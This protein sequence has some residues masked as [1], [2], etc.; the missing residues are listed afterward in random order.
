[1]TG[2]EYTELAMKTRMPSSKNHMYMLL[3]LVAEVGELSGKIAK[4][5]RHGV[6]V[7]NGNNFVVKCKNKAEEDA[8]KE[9]IVYELGDCFWQLH[10]LCDAFGLK[11]EDVQKLNLK[12][13]A[14]RK[15]RDVIDG[16]GDY[17]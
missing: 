4:A 1:M 9:A 17:R 14:D 5:I 6:V 15:K 8:L 12:K 2:N 3:N 7:A 10:G 16:S 11:A 13:L